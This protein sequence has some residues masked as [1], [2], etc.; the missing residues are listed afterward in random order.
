[1][2]ALTPDEARCL[3]A[4]RDSYWDMRLTRLIARWRREAVTAEVNI[5]RLDAELLRRCADELEKVL[6]P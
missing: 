2:P 6:K 4:L 1:M 3:G 5:N